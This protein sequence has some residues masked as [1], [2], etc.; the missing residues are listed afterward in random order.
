MHY[1]VTECQMPPM[2]VASTSQISTARAW[3]TVVILLLAAVLAFVDRQIYGLMI[4][5]IKADLR[6]SDEAMGWLGGPAFAI[7]YCVAGVPVGWAIDRF[8]RGWLIAIGIA[9]WSAMTAA[10]GLASTFVHLLL[11]R[12]GVGVGEATLGPAAHSL[13]AD[14][15][16]RK[17]LPLAM[18]VFAVGVPMGVGLAFLFGGAVVEWVTRA[19]DL[20]WGLNLRPWQGV[21][22]IVGAPGLVMAAAIALWVPEPRGAGAGATDSRSPEGLGVF[23]RAHRALVVSYLIGIGALTAVS[24]AQLTWLP[25]F[26]ARRFG[27]SAGQIGPVISVLIIVFGGGGALGGGALAMRL[28]GRGRPDAGLWII[29]I[30]SAISI[31]LV[32]CATRSA[33]PRTALLLLAPSFLFGSCYVGLGPA[34]VQ[35]IAPAALRGRIA[36]WN[37]MLTS[38]TGM[39]IGPLAVGA[40][41][42][43]LFA[44]DGRVGDSLALVSAVLGA[45]AVLALGFALPRY[46]TAVS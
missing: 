20:P 45:V 4:D 31:P 17:R 13:M 21:F 28:A 23:W 10:C 39:A 24:Y 26:F 19:G 15:F 35:S 25:A 29:A 27:W 42:H 32:A 40:V 46:R 18:G 22:L 2:N 1:G 37:L 11:A 8:H 43:R 7:F 33:D 34:V 16:E 44:A 30:A 9:L 5:P 3:V 36:A 41:T 12:I 38:L 14:L 6:V